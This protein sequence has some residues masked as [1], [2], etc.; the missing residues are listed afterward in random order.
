MA[1]SWFLTELTRH[2]PAVFAVIGLSCILSA[3]AAAETYTSWPG[4]FLREGAGA[5]AIGMGNA[6]TA[7]EG[8]VY[9]TYFNPAGLAAM[10]LN[11]LALSVHYLPFDRRFMHLAYGTR[12]GPD[13]DFGIS[14][15]QAGTEDIVGR[16]LNGNPTHSL[17]DKRNAIGITFAK[18]LGGWIAIGI[19]TKMTLWKLGGDDARTFGFDLGAVVRPMEHL[20]C[21]LVMRDINSRF[22]WTSNSWKKTITGPNGQPIEKKDD[23]PVYYTLGAAYRLFADRLILSATAEKVEDNPLSIN[24]GVSYD[25]TDRFSIRTGFNH[26]TT[27][28]KLDMGSSTF[29]MTLGLTSRTV[30]DYAYVPDSFIGEDIHIISFVMSYDD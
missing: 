12:I 5:R 28:D 24:G 19:N 9:S 29:G 26:Y 18:N 16:D 1:K 22:T 6:Y 2:L 21:S 27:A 8:D 14:W 13:A 20:T 23:F 10:E 25:L 4:E 3:T 11:E 17:E 7:I 30:F 15:I